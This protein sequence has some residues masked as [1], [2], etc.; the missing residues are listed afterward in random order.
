MTPTRR[1]LARMRGL[2]VLHDAAHTFSNHM[3]YIEQAVT[4][5]HVSDADYQ[6]AQ[7]VQDLLSVAC[8]LLQ[9]IIDTEE[10]KEEAEE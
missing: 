10:A 7:D 1:E 2:A 5:L 4:L 9:Q 6:K 8:N 3:D